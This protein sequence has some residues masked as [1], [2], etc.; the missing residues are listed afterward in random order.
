VKAGIL[1]ITPGASGINWNGTGQM[2]HIVREDIKECELK[3]S[4]E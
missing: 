3:R 4:L 2:E 1:I